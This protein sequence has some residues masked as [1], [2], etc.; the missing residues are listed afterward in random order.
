T[1]NVTASLWS[2]SVVP[3]V[4]ADSD[5]SA[6]EIGTKFRSSMAGY[7]TAIRYYKSSTNTG[8]HIGHL[9]SSTGTLLATI[10]FTGE[11]TS[12]W[13]QATLSTPVAINANTTYIVSYYAPTGHY[14]EDDGFFATSY[15]NGPLTAL[16]DGFD[17]PNGVY[18]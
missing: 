14:A 3:G 11:T 7:I 5:G 12:G 10:T 9:W 2:N 8:T 15:S 18:A 4:V 1:T 6:S 17:G 16:A 13:Q